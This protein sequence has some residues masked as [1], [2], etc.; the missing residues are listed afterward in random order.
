MTLMRM[1]LNDVLSSAQVSLP[2]LTSPLESHH[3]ATYWKRV[4]HYREIFVKIATCCAIFLCFGQVDFSSFSV[5][6]E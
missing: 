4:L 2:S 6:L 1:A 3:C 5:H